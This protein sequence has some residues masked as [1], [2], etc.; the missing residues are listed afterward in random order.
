VTASG[1]DSGGI[2]SRIQHFRQQHGLSLNELAERAGVSKSYLWNL[3]KRNEDKRPSAQVL[4]KIA[5]GLGV[6][7]A[8]LLDQAPT[9]GDPDIPPS[10]REF[11]RSRALTDSDVRMLASIQFRGDP[12]QSVRRWQFIYDALLLSRGFDSEVQRAGQDEI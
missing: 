7:L 4:F 12:P 9:V 3:E 11:T 10:L 6:T 5:K 8:D 1:P 2:G